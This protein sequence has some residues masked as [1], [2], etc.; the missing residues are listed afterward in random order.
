MCKEVTENGRRKYFYD[1]R[2]FKERFK[3]FISRNRKINSTI[4]LFPTSIQHI[5]ICNK[6]LINIYF[7]SNIIVNIHI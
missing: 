3:K 5:G 4:L 7:D 1:H 6:T 2:K